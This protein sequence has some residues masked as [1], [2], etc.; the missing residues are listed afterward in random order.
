[1]RIYDFT[2]ELSAGTELTE[3]LGN[4]LFEAGCDDGSPGSCEGVVSIDFHREAE[5]LEAAIRS[6]IADVQKAG[7]TVVKAEIEADA[8]GIHVA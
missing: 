6:A 3:G 7:C 4:S 1:M 5:S 8:P 2:L